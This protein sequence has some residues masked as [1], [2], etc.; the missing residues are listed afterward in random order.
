MKYLVLL[1]LVGCAP[2][3]HVRYSEID[4][5]IETAPTPD[6]KKYYEGRRERF[7]KDAESAEKFYED[8]FN[9][10]A[11]DETIWFCRLQPRDLRRH[12]FKDLDDLVKT[13]RRERTE[14]GCANRDMLM[15]ELE[16]MGI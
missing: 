2:Y 6:E 16:R 10:M 3:P 7:E 15:R 9:C 4:E 12:P 13:Y 11:D 14:C 1:L 8:K 5:A